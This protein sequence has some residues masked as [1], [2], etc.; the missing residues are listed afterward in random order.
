MS[1]NPPRRGASPSKAVITV[2]EAVEQASLHPGEKILY[3]TG[4][5]KYGAR[6]KANDIRIGK[7]GPWKPWTG[8]I[9]T[10]SCKQLDGT[11][12][13]YVYVHED[14]LASWPFPF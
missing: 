13:V 7:R 5:A 2:E 14:D 4:H 3:S 10:S 11:Y 1:T 9:S 6:A 12:N 8:L